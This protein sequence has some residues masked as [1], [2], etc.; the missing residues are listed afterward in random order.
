LEELAILDDILRAIFPKT[1]D[2]YFAGC[3]VILFGDIALLPPINAG[4][5]CV[6][7]ST[8]ADF[9]AQAQHGFHCFSSFLEVY[10][11]RHVFRMDRSD[12]LAL[13]FNQMLSRVR[14]MSPT[15]DD[16]DFLS[17]L[18]PAD[19]SISLRLGS[20]AFCTTQQSAFDYN[21][22]AIQLWKSSASVPV[23]PV[24]TGTHEVLYAAIGARVVLLD[25][26]NITTGLYAGALGT[27][28]S[29]I[30]AQGTR[31]SCFPECIVVQFDKYW[32][33]SLHP[34]EPRFVPIFPRRLSF[35]QGTRNFLPLKL[36]FGVPGYN[37]HSLTM[38]K[39]VVHIGNGAPVPRLLYLAL[40]RVERISDVQIAYLAPS[41]CF[42]DV[43]DV[44]SKR[45]L[46]TEL[47]RLKQLSIATRAQHFSL[48][49]L[50]EQK[51]ELE[52]LQ[53]L[54]KKADY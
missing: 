4:R 20:T 10:E 51:G 1:K 18:S 48:D 2:E 46:L 38:S 22:R 5:K 53:C 41:L 42:E 11:L 28:R 17:S 37:C 43:A 16:L 23:H 8:I 52:V 7:T 50:A 31:C 21:L 13:R 14:L 24:R 27:I 45:L 39:V 26:I 36:A 15:Q 33:P 47:I 19:T 54:K 3:S 35:P 25:N 30:Y 29:I 44:F 32:G 9:G 34:S 49:S 40:S 6:I 12:A